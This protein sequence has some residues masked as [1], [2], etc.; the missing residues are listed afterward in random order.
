MAYLHHH[1]SPAIVHGDLKPSNVLLDEMMTAHVGDFGFSRLMISAAAQDDST[2][3]LGDTSSTVIGSIGY[4][5]PEYGIGGRLSLKGDV[6]SYGIL[7]LETITG[8][9]P[10]DP[11]FSQE[12]QSCSTLQSWVGDAFPDRLLEVIDRDL[13]EE[14]TQEEEDEHESHDLSETRNAIK[15]NGIVVW[16]AEIGMMCSREAWQQRPTMR[17]VEASLEKLVAQIL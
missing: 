13:V 11:V 12:G 16:L 17:E 2:A 4:I 15:G 10:T 5:A 6:Y 9:R 1:S 8:K 3:G 14:I 7:L